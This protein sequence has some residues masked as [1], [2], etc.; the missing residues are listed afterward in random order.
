MLCWVQTTQ[1]LTVMMSRNMSHYTLLPD[2]SSIAIFNDMHDVI[3]KYYYYLQS[4]PSRFTR[5]K[6]AT[7][8]TSGR[9]CTGAIF[10]LQTY[11][12]YYVGYRDLK[13]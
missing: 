11:F 9:L 1:F 7:E 2:Q 4:S 5:F 6:T 3:E 10:P 12:K 8:N 13:S